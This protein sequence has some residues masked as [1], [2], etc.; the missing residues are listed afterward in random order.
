M[1]AIANLNPRV[2]MEFDTSKDA[3]EFGVKYGRQM[4]FNV[5]KHYTNKSKK[6]GNVTSRGLV[7]AKQGIRG[8]EEEDIVLTHNQDDTRTN[9]PLRLYVS[10]VQEAGKYKV[11][12]FVGEHNHTLRLSETIYMMRS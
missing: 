8:T 2:G 6:D 10:L 7:Y 3:W 9:C 1:D 5:R 11:A 4:G 12:D